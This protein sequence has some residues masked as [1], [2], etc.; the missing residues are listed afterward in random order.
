MKKPRLVFLLAV[1]GLCAALCGC[2]RVQA[3]QASHYIHFFV[4]PKELPDGSSTADRMA[5]LRQWL[6]LRAGGY[7][8][9]PAPGGW[10][11]RE[12]QVET[13][14]QAGFFVS[15]PQNLRQEIA[16]K[17]KALFL[18]TDPFVEVWTSVD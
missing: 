1:L 13:S 14:D 9:F 7:T 3:P 12:G 2:A 4:A 11:D 17:I 6:C 16:D 18:E 15:A 8:E 5:Q 10:Q